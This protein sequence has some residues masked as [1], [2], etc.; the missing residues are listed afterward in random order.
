M[1][2]LYHGYV[3]HTQRLYLDF[4]FSASFWGV[5]VLEFG[6][7]GLI[8]SG[9]GFVPLGVAGLTLQASRAMMTHGPWKRASCRDTFLTVKTIEIQ[10]KPSQTQ[11]RTPESD[12]ESDGSMTFHTC[13]VCIVPILHHRRNWFFS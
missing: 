9:A 10:V 11:H 2:H 6:N 12:G 13:I 8:H 3:S 4:H 5:S 1:D 7:L